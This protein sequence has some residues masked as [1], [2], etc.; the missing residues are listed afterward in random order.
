M[1]GNTIFALMHTSKC[2][3]MKF[4]LGMRVFYVEEHNGIHGGLETW[5][6]YLMR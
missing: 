4:R 6:P 3:I 2:F 5:T 1:V